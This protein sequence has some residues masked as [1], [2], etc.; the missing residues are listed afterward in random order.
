MMN[1][2]FWIH[3]LNIKI[4]GPRKGHLFPLLL[5]T[6]LPQQPWALVKAFST[7]EGFTLLVRPE[8]YREGG[9]E[10]AGIYWKLWKT[11]VATCCWTFALGAT[12][13]I[14]PLLTMSP[15]AV[16]CSHCQPPCSCSACSSCP[17]P[18]HFAQAHPCSQLRSHG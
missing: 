14:N 9:W 1:S 16:A 18:Q 6:L 4:I 7:S 17:E 11:W 15:P 3:I 10:S 2:Y 5:A 12:H 13:S 8:S